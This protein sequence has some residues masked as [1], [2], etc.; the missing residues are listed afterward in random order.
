MATIDDLVRLVPSP[1]ARVDATGDWERVETDLGLEL[2]SDF[3]MLI[4]RYGFGQFESFITPLNPFGPHAMLIDEARRL[5]EEDQLFR[6]QHPDTSPYAF[7]LEPGGLLPWAG[8]TGTGSAGFLKA[9]HT[10]GPQLPGTRAPGTTTPTPSAR[11][12]FSTV[13]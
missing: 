13:G 1:E 12:A 5:Q 10:H 2:P 6:E 8:T 4:Q 9:T 7:Y 3:K 11:W